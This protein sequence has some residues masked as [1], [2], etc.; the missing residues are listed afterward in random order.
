MTIKE[1]M[2]FKEAA[3]YVLKIAGEPLS[4]REIVERALDAGCLRTSGKTPGATMAA[5]LYV[6]I[7]K[8]R[9]SRFKKVGGG[10]FALREQTDSAATPL[11]LIEKQNALVRKEFSNRL[12]A[13]DAYQFEYLISDLL[14]AIGYES[15]EVTRRSGDQGIDVSANLTMEGITNVKTVIQVKRYHPGNKISGKIITQLRGSAEVDQRGLVITTSDFTRDAVRESKAPNKMP[16]SLVSG[17]KLLD[18]LLKYEVGVKRESVSIYSLDNE[19]LGNVDTEDKQLSPGGKNRSVWPLPGGN[20]SYVDSLFKSLDA[21]KQ[22]FNTR[23]K[24]IG[25]YKAKFDVVRSYKTAN[26]YVNVLKS[27]GLTIT[28]GGRV[29]LSKDGERLLESRDIEFLY[30]TISRNILAFDDI[31]EFIRTS[32][33]AQSERNVMEFLKENF[34]IE[35]TTYTQVNYRLLW[36]MNLKKIRKTDGGY[37]VV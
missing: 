35:W 19:Y 34:D 1:A 28:E 24:L 8:N 2:S 13:M 36:L 30:E 32:G 18:L 33:E 22:G 23:E 25:W 10:K 37:E 14:K 12:H 7:Q 16:V 21:V 5:Q 27:M 9:K 3:I 29:S 6:D 31:V 17:E 26:G 15:V 11:L 20:N 4:S